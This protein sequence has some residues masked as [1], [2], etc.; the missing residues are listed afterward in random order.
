MHCRLQ[1]MHRFGAVAFIVVEEVLACL[2]L[3][4]M[5]LEHTT[6]SIRCAEAVMNS[7][8]TSQSV[9]NLL[10]KAATLGPYEFHAHRGPNAG[11]C[12]LL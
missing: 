11:I 6:S 12:L 1:N 3:S 8:K 2:Q 4:K 9:G 7:R 10:K 5:S